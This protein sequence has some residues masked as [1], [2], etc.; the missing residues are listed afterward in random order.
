[1]TVSR[2]TI[3]ELHD[4]LVNKEISA[5]ELTQEHLNRI[6]AL[7]SEVNAYIT[8]TGDLAL[9]QAKAVDAKLAAGEPIGA[10]AGIPMAV[11]DNMCTEGINTTCASKMLED[12]KPQYSATVVKKLQEQDYVMLGKVNMDEFA[13]GSTTENSA[14]FATKNPWNAD[15]VPGGSSG[16]SAAS[17]AADLAV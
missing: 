15:C 8:V 7:D 10:L 5:T 3:H 11:K 14:F 9:E 12:F 1:M 17:V 16:G 13:M 2:L 4:L 6:Q